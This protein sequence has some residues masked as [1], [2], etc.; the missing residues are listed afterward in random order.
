MVPHP[1]TS[2]YPE[3]NRAAGLWIGP[4]TADAP[5]V[6]GSVDEDDVS[7]GL[8]AVQNAWRLL[9]MAAAGRIA[10]TPEQR[11]HLERIAHVPS[12]EVTE[13]LGAE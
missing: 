12:S 10:L 8:I 13:A 4:A 5:I 11:A 3:R 6:A 2:V 9:Q 1:V 7:T